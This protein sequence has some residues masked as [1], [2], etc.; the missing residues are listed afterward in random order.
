MIKKFSMAALSI[1]GTAQVPSKLNKGRG[2][3]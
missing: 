1:D 3:I 2:D